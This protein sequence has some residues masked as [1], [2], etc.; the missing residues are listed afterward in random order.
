MVSMQHPPTDDNTTLHH[1]WIQGGQT[2]YYQKPNKQQ[3]Q[4]SIRG[5]IFQTK[6]LEYL[7]GS[8]NFGALYVAHVKSTI[9]KTVHKH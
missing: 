9:T 1:T 2:G 8:P 5:S 6:Y 3:V 4:Y 7:P